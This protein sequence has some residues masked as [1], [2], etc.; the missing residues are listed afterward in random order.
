MSSVIIVLFGLVIA[1]LNSTPLFEIFDRQINPVFWGSTNLAEEAERFQ[2][3]VYSVLGATVAGWGITL[4]F[5][6]RCPFQTKQKWAWMC[7]ITAMLVWYMA[8]T[9]LSLHFG[10][11]INA[12]IN[13]CLFMLVVLPLI[14]TYKQFFNNKE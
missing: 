13:T 4:F 2:S 3:W 14:M 6:A 8:D 5:I 9:T 10:V 7:I 1:F 12:I 11:I